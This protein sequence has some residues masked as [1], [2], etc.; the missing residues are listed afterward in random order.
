MASRLSIGYKYWPYKGTASSGIGIRHFRYDAR[1]ARSASSNDA[2][3]DL[4]FSHYLAF[5]SL[6][7]DFDGKFMRLVPSCAQ[8]ISWAHRLV[9]LLLYFRYCQTKAILDSAL[10]CFL[11]CAKEQRIL[12]CQNWLSANYLVDGFH[13]I[14]DFEQAI[15]YFAADRGRL[16]K[17]CSGIK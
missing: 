15:E 13:V 5:T 9:I 17:T 3:D 1:E 7:S 11:N 12:S 2:D 8:Q 4:F 10:F 6:E 16:S 14:I